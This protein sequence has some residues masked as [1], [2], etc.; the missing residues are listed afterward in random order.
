MVLSAHRNLFPLGRHAT[1]REYRDYLGERGRR[2]EDY[3]VFTLVRCPYDVLPS[4]YE[5]WNR[6]LARNKRYPGLASLRERIG[7]AL[8]Y[9]SF[10]IHCA[11]KWVERYIQKRLR[12]IPSFEFYLVGSREGEIRIFRLEDLADHSQPLLDYLG[13]HGIEAEG[14]P[15]FNRSKANRG[16]RELRPIQ[17]WIAT[18]IYRR[19]L[20]RFYPERLEHGPGPA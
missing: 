11:R 9:T 4:Q 13:R 3:A 14:L 15:H 8:F 17:R 6:I 18:R 10:T 2:I 7:H 16:G 20:A 19:E 1:Y 12:F 5:H